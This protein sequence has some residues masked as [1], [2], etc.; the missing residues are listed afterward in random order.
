MNTAHEPLA[1]R[2]CPDQLIVAAMPRKAKKGDDS[3]DDLSLHSVIYAT[4]AE[5]MKELKNIN[6]TLTILQTK[7]CDVED[8]LQK[9]LEK[10]RR[11][12]AEIK[13][14]KEDVLIIKENYDNILAEVEDRDR[15]KANLILSGLPEKEVGTVEERKESDL[16]MVKMLFSVLDNSKKDAVSAVFRIGKM[17]SSKPRLLKVTCRDT[18]SKRVLL[19]KSKDLRKKDQY[20][21]V[22]INPDMTPLQ[23]AQNRRLREELRARRNLGEDVTIRHA[24]ESR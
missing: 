17:T 4:K 2:F 5:L 10:Q 11:Q 22:Y 23:Q 19:S 6:S 21:N 14:L 13:L 7:I 9:V 12:D 18:E 24:R 20:K 1:P 8:T 3:A 16:L 15:R